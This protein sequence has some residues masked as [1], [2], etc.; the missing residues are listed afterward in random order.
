MPLK[1]IIEETRP[2]PLHFRFQC[3]NKILDDFKKLREISLKTISYA[4]RGKRSEFHKEAHPNRLSA[5]IG[6]IRQNEELPCIYFC[7]SR[8]RCEELAEELYN[9]DF[10]QEDER[11]DILKLFNELIKRYDLERE[12]STSRMY[13]LVSRGIA[14]HHAGMLPTLKRGGRTAFY[15]TPFKGDIYH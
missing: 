3:Q 5:L 9:F 11:E 6:H 8:R 12:P 2:V 10:L 4:Y 1:I 13:P 14:Y 15:L 7:F